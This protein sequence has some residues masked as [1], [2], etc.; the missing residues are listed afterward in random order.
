[1]EAEALHGTRAHSQNPIALVLNLTGLKA[2]LT[3]LTASL[4]SFCSLA[5]CPGDQPGR[6]KPKPEFNLPHLTAPFKAVASWLRITALQL[7][8]TGWT[9]RGKETCAGLSPHSLLL[10]PQ[11]L[12]LLFHLLCLSFQSLLSLL[13]LP[14]CPLKLLKTVT[15]GLHCRGRS[16]W[17]FLDQ[18]CPGAHVLDFQIL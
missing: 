4:D 12:F 10:P 9:P 13:L 6:D 18:T 17:V 1:M 11:P 14:C 2:P 3:G 15:G 8:T 5:E 16:R 7:R